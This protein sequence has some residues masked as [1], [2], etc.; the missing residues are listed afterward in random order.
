MTTMHYIHSGFERFLVWSMLIAGS[1]SKSQ[2]VFHTLFAN[3]IAGASGADFGR[4]GRL[5]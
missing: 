1:M 3:R 4:F 2:S 5:V